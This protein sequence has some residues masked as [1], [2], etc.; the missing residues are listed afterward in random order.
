[1]FIINLNRKRILISTILF[2]NIQI[3]YSQENKFVYS[4]YF[5]TT[6]NIETIG[7]IDYSTLSKPGW[8]KAYCDSIGPDTT[9]LIGLACSLSNPEY[10]LIKLDQPLAKGHQYTINFHYKGLCSSKNPPTHL[11]IVPSRSKITKINQVNLTD[12]IWAEIPQ[13]NDWN[14]VT[15]TIT[16]DNQKWLLIG[17]VFLQIADLPESAKDGYLLINRIIIKEL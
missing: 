9:P 11:E 4:N 2:L 14:F 7:S 3:T 13:T 5:E 16:G 10:I 1:M 12:I 6:E 17:N 8:W 15:A